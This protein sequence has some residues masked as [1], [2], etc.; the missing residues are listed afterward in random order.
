MAHIYI[1]DR[2]TFTRTMTARIAERIEARFGAQSVISGA[3]EAAHG[4]PSAAS[5]EESLRL[6][7]AVLVIIGGDW[8]DSRSA[9]GARRLD[10]P[11][12]PVRLEIETALRLHLALIP[13]LLDGTPLPAAGDL[14]ESLQ[15]LARAT[16][17][18]VR[19][20]YEFNRDIEQVLAAV[21]RAFAADAARRAFEQ[22]AATV[23]Q[24][25]AGSPTG[26]AAPTL[27]AVPSARRVRRGLAFLPRPL[28]VAIAA[29][30]VLAVCAV[31]VFTGA[32]HGGTGPL[33]GQPGSGI[34]PAQATQT[35]FA[36][37]TQTVLASPRLP[38]FAAA[39]GP[40]CDPGF[41]PWQS[42]V[43]AVSF[44]GTIT[45]A[46]DHTHV[47]G[48]L[49]CPTCGEGGFSYTVGSAITLP[50]PFT[51]SV[52]I[53]HLGTD[54]NAFLELSLDEL[55]NNGV[56]VLELDS[57]NAAYAYASLFDKGKVPA[58][59][60][61]ASASD[62]HTL[63]MTV[64]NSTVT[65]AIDGQQFGSRTEPQ[66]LHV[67]VIVMTMQTKDSHGGGQV[68]FSNLSIHA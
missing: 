51:V 59:S 39:P 32:L 60:T 5:I 13:V 47:T 23:A 2:R 30:V 66:P 11:T 33:P 57:P 24:A 46:P 67:L 28:M 27:S 10:D 4:E 26:A 7:S 65:F 58:G 40:R 42:R 18:P 25:A 53:S 29:V 54:S 61:T 52:Q 22:R 19:S 15:P 9:D 31:L 41:Y 35:Q 38:Y 17:L 62:T 49:G 50:N 64:H 63:S 36:W 43:G 6:C 56:E 34:S 55:N 8:L 45:C 37:A 44:H 14:P 48:T 1:S 20:G 3:A 12:D 68:D 21:E 16:S